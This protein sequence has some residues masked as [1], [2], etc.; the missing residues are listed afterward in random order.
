MHWFMWYKM[1]F[2]YSLVSCF[3]IILYYCKLFSFIILLFILHWVFFY[4]SVKRKIS[5]CSLSHKH[6][7]WK[8]DLTWS[9]QPR[10]LERNE[11]S[12]E[13][14][15]G[16]SDWVAFI[17]GWKSMLWQTQP[18]RLNKYF[19]CSI[20]G[21]CYKLYDVYD[22]PHWEPCKE[23]MIASVL[24]IFRKIMTKERL[25]LQGSSW[26]ATVSTPNSNG[27]KLTW[28]Q[29]PPCF[30]HLFFLISNTFIIN[31]S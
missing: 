23:T 6:F 26:L 3:I 2:L 9:H 12:F 25:H 19:Y 21:L 16:S 22:I 4:S 15:L 30:T 11:S 5:Y 10:S 29:F 17:P 31:T 18:H 20:H 1:V 8:M 7:T 14:S 28:T 27:L 24:S 13:V